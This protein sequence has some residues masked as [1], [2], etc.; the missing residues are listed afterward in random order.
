MLKCI[1]FYAEMASFQSQLCRRCWSRVVYTKL[2]TDPTEVEVDIFSHFVDTLTVGNLDVER[3]RQNDIYIHVNV[4]AK[5]GHWLSARQG[6]QMAY[7][8]TQTPNLG[9]FCTVLQWTMSVY[10]MAFWPIL[11]P[12]GRFH[13]IYF[14]PFWYVAARKIWQPCW[15]FG[16][17]W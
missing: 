12:F 5:S 11:L 8:Q 4:T 2:T 15:R 13:G 7:F 16:A 9:T 3:S 17:A 14:F 1:Y 10:F 6:C